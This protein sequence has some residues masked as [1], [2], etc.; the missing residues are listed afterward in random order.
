MH[1][2]FIKTDL[3]KQSNKFKYDGISGTKFIFIK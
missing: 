2:H 1:L 3:L